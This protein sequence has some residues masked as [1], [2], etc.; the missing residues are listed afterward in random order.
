[1]S[2]VAGILGWRSGL[3]S[4]VQVKRVKR[5]VRLKVLLEMGNGAGWRRRCR[6]GQVGPTTVP[7]RCSAGSGA[8]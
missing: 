5:V 4:L 1:M 8:E 7:R 2:Y 6:I 3:G